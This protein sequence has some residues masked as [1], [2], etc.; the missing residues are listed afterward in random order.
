MI[1]RV[2]E[3]IAESRLAHAL[4]LTGPD[5]IG[6]LAFATALAQYVNCQAP[7]GEDSCGKCTQCTKIAKGIHPDVR[8][9]YPIISKKEGG[10]QWLSQ[11]FYATFREH[12]FAE[13]YA[14]QAA[15]QRALGG[16]SKQLMISVHEIRELKRNIFLKAF[17]APYKVVIVWQADLINVQGANAFLKLLEE[18]PDKTLIILTS[19]HPRQLINTIT[20]RCQRMA[21]QRIERSRVR[22]YLARQKG[23][24]DT[25]AEG[26]AAIA[27]GSVGNAL[28]YADANYQA[29]ND[30]YMN[31]LRAIYTGNYAKIND[32]LELLDAES[33]EYQKRFLDA[34]L[35]KFR[36]SLFF[37]LQLPQLALATSAETGFHEKFSPFI[38][39][40]K[41][42]RI[43]Q[44]LKE[45]YKDISGNANAM[46]TFS[47]LSVQL[48]QIIRSA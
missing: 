24:P 32:Q 16:E 27:E 30:R 12:F 23:L 38:S 34:A 43:S 39:P 18:P 45:A 15:W 25:E 10:K 26:L 1:H 8:Y 41:V 35:K 29:L 13:P 28:E 36:D 21:L 20:S 42:D 46:M 37:H 44:L 9:I 3:S 33:K 6:K 19:S 22:D 2:R 48:H 40:D 7:A 47:A 4:L 5:G 31:W 17:E 11:D 14:S